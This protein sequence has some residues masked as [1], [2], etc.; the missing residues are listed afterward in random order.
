MTW[1]CPNCEKT[2]KQPG[3]H[4]KLCGVSASVLF[5]QKVNKDH[6]SGCWQW[7]GALQRDG[8]AHF[9]LRR[10]TTSSHRW[11]YEQLVGPIPEGMDLLHSCDNRACVNPAHLR[12][13]THLQNMLDAKAK[14][15]NPH[16]E[17]SASAI[18][19]EALVREMRSRYRMWPS[20]G[21][22]GLGSNIEELVVAYPAFKKSTIYHAVR[23]NTWKH[24]K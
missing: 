14:G 1:T 20:G 23:G 18:L 16:G 2:M 7:T 11:A 13:G 3:S 4:P 19:T 22:W 8:Y 6:P 12:P 5:W 9:G 10:K 21:R 24:V 17:R 15:R